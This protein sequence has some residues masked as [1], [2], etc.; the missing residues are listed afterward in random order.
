MLSPTPALARQLVRQARPTKTRTTKFRTLLLRI[1]LLYV[2][3]AYF[4]VCPH[5]GGRTADGS[6]LSREYRVCSAL[7]IVS[8]HATPLLT[9]YYTTYVAPTLAHTIMPLYET[10]VAPVVDS[11]RPL[12]RKALVLSRPLVA[13]ISRSYQSAIAPHLVKAANEATAL[14][15]AY[16]ARWG[17]GFER[18]LRPTF[19]WYSREILGWYAVNLE[20]HVSTARSTVEHALARSNQVVTPVLDKALPWIS[21]QLYSRLLPLSKSTLANSKHVY[22]TILVPRLV[23]SYVLL[24]ELVTERLVPAAIS[25]WETYGEPQVVKIL[26]KIGEYRNGTKSP[27]AALKKAD[28]ETPTVVDAPEPESEVVVQPITIAPAVVV[29][30]KVVPLVVEPV[31]DE[32]VKDS[33]APVEQVKVEEVEIKP[34]RAEEQIRPVKVEEVAKAEEPTVTPAVE[35]VV[36]EQ[37]DELP[38]REE[39]LENVARVEIIELEIVDG[40]EVKTREKVIVVEDVDDLDGACPLH[41]NSR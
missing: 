14:I 19:E 6:V 18:V 33:E 3:L 28:I 20:P 13:R 27:V 23:Q 26:E 34:V 41:L 9:P 22:E 21:K 38:I 30:A 31:A 37:V 7:D 35:S 36:E 32:S 1:A 25:S 5:D 15:H 11:V 8:T 2:G 4:Y 17:K 29:P 10:R 39:D 24:C 40:V 16:T 12:V